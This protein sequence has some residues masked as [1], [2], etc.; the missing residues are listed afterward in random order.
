[1]N[2]TLQREMPV[3]VWKFL[4]HKREKNAGTTN[5]I[6]RIRNAELYRQNIRIIRV[7]VMQFLRIRGLE[8]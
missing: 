4:L 5:K 1:M 3:V 7:R 6:R 8:L 2:Y